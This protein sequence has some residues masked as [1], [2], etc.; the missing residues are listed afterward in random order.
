MPRNQATEQSCDGQTE[1]DDQQYNSRGR[2]GE[3]ARTTSTRETNG[4]GHNRT[5]P[6]DPSFNVGG[7][8]HR[9]NAAGPQPLFQCWLVACD[10]EP[11]SLQ[12][13]ATSQH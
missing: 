11:T 7:D 1:R 10:I 4:R 9:D 2:D 3:H 8:E 13:I 6:P 12:A 5:E